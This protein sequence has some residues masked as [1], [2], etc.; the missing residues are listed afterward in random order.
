[1]NPLEDLRAAM[2]AAGL[3]FAGQFNV[4]DEFQRFD[5]AGE[6][7]E[8]SYYSAHNYGEVLVVTFGCFR[9]GIQQTWCS[10]SRGD[11]S[12]QQWGEVSR[13]WK[14]Q[15]RQRDE[16]EKK[17]NAQARE[18]CAKW[19]GSVFPRI[20]DHPYLTLKGV[21]A[22]GPL[23]LCFE[24]RHKNWL[25]LPLQDHLGVIHTAEFIAQDGTKDYLWGGRK[26]GCYFPVSEV[27]GGP[28]L[29]CEGYATGASLALATGW[30]V[31]CAMD[32][33]NLLPAAQEIRKR[34]PNRSILFCSDN[35]QFSEDNPGATK[36]SA[37]AKAVRGVVA[38]PQFGDESL[39]DKPTDFNDLHRIDGLPEVRRQI[40]AAMPVVARPI[41]DFKVP[42][43]DDPT[44]LLKYR[45]LCEHGSLLFNGPAGM[46][47][48]SALVQ[49]AG[50]WANVLDFFGMIPRKPLKTLII[51]AENDDGDIA[52]MRDGICTGLH[53]T[54][55]QRQC[56]FENVLIYS[57]WGVTGR[58]FCQEVIRPLL[59]LHDPNLVA[60]DPALS[61]IGG[62]VKEQK[63]VG[64]FLREY[65]NPV[66]FEH[67][68]ACIVMHHTNKPLT[69]KEK[70]SWRNGE[71][72]YTG[73]GSAEWANWPRAVIA[74][75]S[76]GN[77]GYYNL[78]ASKRG[79]RL[80]WTNGDDELI[81]QKLIAW[82]KDKNT[83]FW[84]EPDP[85]ELPDETPKT[86]TVFGGRPNTVS[87]IATMNS[88]EFLAACLP[89]G[90]SQR[91]ISRRLESWLA[92]QHI[93]ASR[94]TC[95]RA[96]DSLVDNQKLAKDPSSFLYIKGPNA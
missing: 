92:T 75:Q 61:F 60:I 69:G 47:K 71:L 17:K 67:A 89:E 80:G 81:Y 10:R 62:D 66:I 25:A 16:E 3:N 73:S 4:N 38:T 13:A 11:L 90:E 64:Q 37:A 42:E 70:G 6:K 65:L 95:H 45:Y 83:I 2:K 28:I 27:P 5:C 53:F 41:G 24:E 72:A 33:G 36:A 49:A 30:T 46:G 50:L 88:H 1:M 63:V 79:A 56:F 87:K 35:D 15:A 77:A 58:A 78:H 85:D 9:R 55:E 20:K 44:E 94:N 93:S 14:E 51:Q 19:F 59:D 39:A 26:K 18:K 34:H 82:S 96:I 23:Y 40:Y 54:K 57:S 29:I 12:G 32:C 74:L 22:L 84:R 76:T 7:G 48:S 21:P 31:I 43:K 86:R 52:Q 8:A 68:C 91:A